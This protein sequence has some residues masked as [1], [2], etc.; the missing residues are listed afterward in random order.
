MLLVSEAIS[1]FPFSEEYHGYFLIKLYNEYKE[2]SLIES[3][4]EFATIFCQK[5][6]EDN[7][8]IE[9]IFANSRRNCVEEVCKLLLET[10]DQSMLKES[11]EKLNSKYR[12]YFESLII[13]QIVTLEDCIAEGTFDA[14]NAKIVSIKT[15]QEF[16]FFSSN[17]RRV[18]LIEDIPS[19][20]SKNNC[21]NKKNIDIDTE[22]A[23]LITKLFQT[24]F[25]NGVYMSDIDLLDIQLLLYFSRKTEPIFQS[26]FNGSNAIIFTSNQNVFQ[27]NYNLFSKNWA[28]LQVKNPVSHYADNYIRGNYDYFKFLV[29][30]LINALAIAD[31]S[32]I[33]FFVNSMINSYKIKKNI[34]EKIILVSFG[35]L[36]SN[37][38]KKYL[39][40]YFQKNNFVYAMFCQEKFVVSYRDKDSRI[41][42]SINKE[43]IPL[44]CIESQKQYYHDAF[45][46]AKNPNKNIKLLVYTS[47]FVFFAFLL[48]LYIIKQYNHIRRPILSLIRQ[49]PRQKI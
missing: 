45:E 38:N 22:T 10:S 16:Q 11:I 31:E 35:V 44:D 29:Q 34:L 41:L 7:E 39:D 37:K 30:Y 32:L 15:V 8:Y 4:S 40:V 20:L 12:P 1:L 17:L 5:F 6:I 9:E 36:F 24:S 3:Y 49:S 48:F 14:I 42:F 13:R 19:F 23:L 25:V 27:K 26:I 21:G 18:F 2:Y 47:V 43:Q 46:Y 28:K 33:N